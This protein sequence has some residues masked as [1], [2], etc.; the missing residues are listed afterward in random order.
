MES[1]G[2]LYGFYDPDQMRMVFRNR[3]KKLVPKV[4]TLEKCVS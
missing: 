3:S 1:V 2:K 4:T